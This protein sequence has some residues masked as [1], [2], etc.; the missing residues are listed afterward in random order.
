MLFIIVNPSL[1]FFSSFSYSHLTGDS[2]GPN[3]GFRCACS[4]SNGQQS[5][6]DEVFGSIAAEA[7][8]VKSVEAVAATEGS[9]K[10]TIEEG[11]T[12]GTTLKVDG[13]KKQSSSV[14]EVA[15]EGGESN[16]EESS[17][18]E[19]VGE[20]EGEGEGEGG[21]EERRHRTVWEDPSAAEL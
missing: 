5:M 19:G 7:E 13:M 4:A 15:E 3:V 20:G 6:A 1:S 18:G 21:R 8:G 2:T 16:N 14:V 12:E 9:T 10:G 11:T 17:R